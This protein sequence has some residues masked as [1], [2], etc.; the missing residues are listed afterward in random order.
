MLPFE[1]PEVFDVVISRPTALGSQKMIH[2]R[3]SGDPPEFRH[4]IREL[5]SGKKAY[6]GF[7]MASRWLHGG[8]S[9]QGGFCDALHRSEFRLKIRLRKVSLSW[10]S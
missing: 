6:D 4:A 10:P 7:T 8:T 9:V 2:R 5:L 1:A 3:K